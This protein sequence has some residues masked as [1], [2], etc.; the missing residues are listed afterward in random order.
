MEGS[1]SFW[2]GIDWATQAHQVCLMDRQGK[3][4]QEF[5]V[6]QTGAAL[7]QFAQRLMRLCS[8][9]PQQVAVAIETPRGA[10]VEMLVERGFAVFAINPKQLDRFRDRHTVAGAKDDRRDAFVLADS[11]RTDQHCFRRV[12][13]DDPLIIQIRELS[14]IDEDLCQ[15]GNRLSNRLRDLL[16]RFFPQM[17]E[18]SSPPD[19]RWLWEL[20]ECA[21]TPEK[22][23][24]LRKQTVERILRTHRVRRLTA[25]QV[26]SQLKTPPLPV[27]PG[28]VEACST[29]VGL[30]LPRLRLIQDQRQSCQKHLEDS[31]GR[32]DSGETA[33]AEEREHRDVEILRSLPGVG[34]LV[35]ATMLAEASQ[36]LKD[37]DYQALR[38]Y[39]GV[40]PVTKSSGKRRG[41]RSTVIM[42]RACNP[43]LRRAVYHWTRVSVQ[44]DPYSK[45]LY[46]ALRGRGHL[47]ARALRGVGDRLL[48]IL[49]S[50]L[51]H[52]TL[53]EP[54]QLPRPSG[55]SEALKA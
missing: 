12:R 37:R 45:S 40:A 9:D 55:I 29:H 50:M 19:D 36:P 51:K 4:C 49:V 1:F 33:Q 11:L 5:A 23:G 28:V 46:A 35:A 10:V 47:H 3:T 26:L 2:V 42:R 17:V 20:L 13:L 7:S 34:R 24:R 54:R 21:P 43:R 8:E 14:R 30:L 22:A 44:K 52:G 6:E 53:Y 18:L 27:A 15:E 39:T 41:K 25:Q 16:H 48:K 32:I 38:S 31:L